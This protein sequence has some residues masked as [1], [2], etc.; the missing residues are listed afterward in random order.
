MEFYPSLKKNEILSHVLTWANLKEIMLSETG[1]TEQ[2][3]KNGWNC[4]L[5]SRVQLSATPWTI[6]SMEFSRPEYWSG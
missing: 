2:Q 4:K 3:T 5:L 6:E 1:V